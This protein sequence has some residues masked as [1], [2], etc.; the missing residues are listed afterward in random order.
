MDPCGINI[1]DNGW[2]WRDWQKYWANISKLCF[3]SFHTKFIQTIATS[4]SFVLRWKKVT[5]SCTFRII[6]PSKGL[7]HSVSIKKVPLLGV[8]T[9]ECTTKRR[10][11]KHSNECLNSDKFAIRFSLFFELYFST[12]VFFFSSTQYRHKNRIPQW[13][14]KIFT[15]SFIRK[16]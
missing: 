1:I 6:L 15:T 13:V 9:D 4:L 10:T 3:T 14:M 5:S 16:L 7:S 11:E 8:P 12:A 2:S